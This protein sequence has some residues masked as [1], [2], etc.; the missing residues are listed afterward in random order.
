MTRPLEYDLTLTGLLRTLRA[1]GGAPD[2][3]GPDCLDDVTVAALTDGLLAPATRAAALAHVARCARCRTAVAS[4]ARA[5]AGRDLARELAAVEGPRWRRATR[6]ALPVAAAA[7]L[8]ILAWPRTVDDGAPA[9]RAPTM[10]TA[11]ASAAVAPVGVVAAASALRWTSVDGADRYR[12]T[13]FDRHARVLYALDLS[14]TMAFLPDS[15]RL[16]PGLRY[17]WKVEAR[18]GFDRWVASDLIEFTVARDTSR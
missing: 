18:T 5:R 12:V 10:T 14:D 9:H 16:V 17:L 7:V 4:V 8:V 6:V 13:L 2:P 3:I 15:V 11:P 1:G